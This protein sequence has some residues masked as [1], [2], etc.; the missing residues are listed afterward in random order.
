MQINSSLSTEQL[1]TLTLGAAQKNHPVGQIAHPP[2]A[3]RTNRLIHCLISS[4]FSHVYV[5]AINVPFD[6][7]IGQYK[8]YSYAVIAWRWFGS[9]TVRCQTYDQE[10]VLRVRLLI[11]SLLT[12][13]YLDGWLSVDRWTI[14]VYNQDQVKLVFHPFKGALH[15]RRST[16][17]PGQIW[18][19]T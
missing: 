13:Y 4:T 16:L 12:G 11:K 14:S 18:I 17:N 2:Q 6:T 7:S 9:V 19:W 1:Y 3:F 10:M 8:L 5:T 15:Q